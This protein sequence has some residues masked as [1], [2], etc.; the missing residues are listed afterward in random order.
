MDLGDLIREALDAIRSHALRSFLT[1]LGIIIGVATIVGVVSVIAGLDQYVQERIII[2]SPDVYVVTKFGIIRG[3]E[4]FLE[5]LK[6]KD[7]T[8]DDVRRLEGSLTRAAEIATQLDGARAAVKFRDRRLADV[9]VTGVT[10]NFPQLINFDLES[11]RFFVE[12][13]ERA[14]APVAVVGWDIKDE[15]FPQLDP[16]GRKVLIGGRE[17]EVIGLVKKQGRTLGQSQ[18]NLVAIPLEAALQQ[19]GT[20]RSLDV[21]IRAKGGV[22]GVEA[23]VDEVR[24]VMRALRHTPF[25]NEDPFGVV[26]AEALQELWR[27]ISGAAFVLMFLIA[28]VS[29]G[30]G[31]IVI[32]NIMLVSVLERTQEIGVR[33]AVGANESDVRRQFLLEA[34]ILSLAGGIVGAAVG[35][36]AA[37]LVESQ[38]GFPARVTPG[39]IGLGL[40]LS[41]LVGLVAG[42]FPARSAA[43]LDVVE[44]LR[45]E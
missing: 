26:T 14:A 23:S 27:N 3:R 11:G 28:S 19:F 31:G 8:K 4:E 36:G 40:G 22:P 25:K 16:V 1:L 7:I 39:I 29:L 43:R 44:A 21:V 32:M 41:V 38:T 13:E 37:S 24:G 9:R 20:R 35:A 6:R 5:A 18:D 33:K 45:A 34:A 2:L 42:Y 17:Y 10:A 30:V 15:L 12:A